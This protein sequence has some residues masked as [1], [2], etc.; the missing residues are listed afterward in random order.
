MANPWVFQNTVYTSCYQRWKK[1]ISH[2][3][4]LQFT[5]KIGGD[6]LN[7]LDVTMINDN[8]ILEFIS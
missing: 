2:Y 6:R 3:A 5:L 1:L 4:R 8:D 7:F